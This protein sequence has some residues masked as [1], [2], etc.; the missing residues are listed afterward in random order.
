MSD[1]LKLS[2]MIAVLLAAIIVPFMIWGEALDALAPE[3]LR[4][5]NTQVYIGIIGVALLIAD[6]LLPVPSSIVSALLCVLL[7]PW[8]GAVAIAI[9]MLGGFVAGYLLGRLLPA[10]TL[11]RWVGPALW[12]ATR[13]KAQR[14]AVMWIVV[15]RPVPVLAEAVSVLAGSL[16]MPCISALPA[17]ALSSA[18]VAACYGAAVSIGFAHGSFW[19]AFGASLLLASG[20][21]FVSSFWRSRIGAGG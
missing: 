1:G 16:R 8:Y 17:A 4:Q 19:L 7:G 9:G 18:V 14:N 5:Q 3:L 11:R 6:V 13:D 10:Q 20:A 12:D 15:T 2:V 21:W